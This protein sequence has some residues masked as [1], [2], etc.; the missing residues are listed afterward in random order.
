L[1]IIIMDE[2]EKVSNTTTNVV[3]KEIFVNLW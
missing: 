1:Q 2:D 3:Y